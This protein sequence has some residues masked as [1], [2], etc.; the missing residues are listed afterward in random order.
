MFIVLF[1]ETSAQVF[2]PKS[3][4]ISKK[5]FETNVCPID[6]GA[7]AYYIFDHGVSNFK[8]DKITNKGFQLIF[9][10]HF[11]L[12]I[13]DKEGLNW[14]DISIR[15]YKN[16]TDKEEVSKI[17]AY[18]YNL[19]KGKV[20]KTK[21][22]KDGIL[23]E[24]TGENRLTTKFAMPN[25]K[26]GSIIDIEYEIKSD[27]IFNLQEWYFQRTIPTLYSD[28]TV[29]IPEYFNYNKVQKGY[30]PVKITRET[31]R[32]FI[33]FT[34]K[35]RS[36]SKVG[37]ATQFYSQNIDY[38]ENIDHF[39]AENI[40]AFPNEKFL[41]T[42]NNYIS[43][44]EY[45]LQS[46]IFPGQPMRSYTTS[47]AGIDE[48]LTDN[49]YF[50]KELKNGN[51][52]KDE[53]ESLKT[54]GIAGEELIIAAYDLVK[55][56]VSWN[57]EKTKYIKTNLNKAYK[58]GEGN[59]ADVNLNLVVLLREL[60]FKSY[61][62][63]LS[64]KENGIIHPA[65]PSISI[66]N[67]VIALVYWEGNPLLMDATDPYSFINLLPVRC[68]NDKGR[69]IGDV[70]EK[71]IDLMNYKSYDVNASYSFI[72]DSAFTISGKVQKNMRDYSA[73]YYRSKLKKS[74]DIEDCVKSMED[75]DGDNEISDIQL[76]GIDSLD[77]TLEIRYNFTGN[78]SVT[79][80]GSMVYFSPVFD[81]FFEENPF[82]LEQREFPVEFDHPYS[83]KRRYTYIIPP[84]YEFSEIPKPIALKVGESDG[85][86]I[87]KISAYANILSI[88][89][90]ID[91]NKSV[92][93]PD[94]YGQLK[95]FI[96]MIIDKEKEL[97]IIK[98]K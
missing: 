28:Y 96:Q 67:Y 43:K 93:I 61:P 52:W 75:Q 47:W 48:R 15:L 32:S 89:T 41:R 85:F 97:V 84:D 29:A 62:V 9:S 92:F 59:C 83:V 21:L 24:E 80:S 88:S 95:A 72:V 46:T 12:K 6:S 1:N 65:H 20:E 60:G 34:D 56:K 42:V 66:F 50:G 11:R 14:G 2:L 86:F 3:Q 51:H 68:L 71:W 49:E 40:Q 10:R 58:S 90:K 57:G 82:K 91:I 13:I 4:E 77:N 39:T 69:I 76:T 36:N 55:R 37:G 78:E 19:E 44:V 7:H 18:T 5:D 16:N 70:S 23:K 53:I 63:I 26:E 35:E 22:E 98:S 33:T 54:K 64:T 17:K 74:T 94:E 87:Y 38:T 27:F 73:Y 25:V 8:Y 79:N 81:P 31:K 30:C 45:E